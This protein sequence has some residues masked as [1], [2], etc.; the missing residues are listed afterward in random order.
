MVIGVP[1]LCSLDEFRPNKVEDQIIDIDCKLIDQTNQVKADKLSYQDFFYYTD[2]IPSD[3]KIFPIPHSYKVSLNN[4]NL[5]PCGHGFYLG[6]SKLPI[7]SPSVYFNFRHILVFNDQYHSSSDLLEKLGKMLKVCVG[8]KILSPHI[9]N[10]RQSLLSWND[11]F[12]L[13][14]ELYDFYGSFISLVKVSRD[15]SKEELELKLRLINPE[16]MLDQDGDLVKVPEFDAPN[17]AWNFQKFSKGK[18]SALD[19]TNNDKNNKATAENDKQ[20]QS[21]STDIVTV[22]VTESL[23]TTS[24]EDGTE[25]VSNEMVIL[26]KLA[27]KLGMTDINE[28]HQAIEDL[29]IELEVQH[30]EL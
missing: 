28:L 24:S 19:S 2:D 16:T 27:D 8:N 9:E 25:E 4:Y 14:F 29:D 7:N 23:E 21:T 3:N 11:T 18:G 5:S 20:Y 30:D 26:K 6:Q 17:N 13:W 1:K 10:K 22:T 15:G 12:I